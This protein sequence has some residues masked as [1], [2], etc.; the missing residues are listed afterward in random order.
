MLMRNL[1]KREINRARCML[2]IRLLFQSVRVSHAF[3][4]KYINLPIYQFSI[5][6][7]KRFFDVAAI[8][9]F[10]VISADTAKGNCSSLGN[11]IQILQTELND[12][13]ISIS[14]CDK[15]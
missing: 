7:I 8:C 15:T 5:L 14:E 13:T 6:K 1:I 10:E 9:M 12:I 3:P 11:S 2:N 4:D